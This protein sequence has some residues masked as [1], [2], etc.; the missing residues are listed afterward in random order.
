MIGLEAVREALVDLDRDIDYLEDAI[1]ENDEGI[2]DNLYHIERNDDAIHDNDDEIED[3][4]R[5]AK[6]LQR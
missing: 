5:R 1:S 6:R 3:Q 4:Q 2:A